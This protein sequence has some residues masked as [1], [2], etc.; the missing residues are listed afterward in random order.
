MSNS[1]SFYLFVSLRMRGML[2][3]FWIFYVFF[4]KQ[5]RCQNNLNSLLFAIISVVWIPEFFFYRNRRISEGEAAEK[6]SY[7]FLMRCKSIFKF[8]VQIHTGWI[9]DKG[10]Q[11]PNI[12]E[13]TQVHIRLARWIEWKCSLNRKYSIPSSK[14][15]SEWLKQKQRKMNWH[16]LNWKE[17]TLLHARK[18]CLFSNHFFIK[19]FGFS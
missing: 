1:D 18:K 16:R 8:A 15:H 3:V 17:K 2:I 19:N 5:R 13:K 6:Q 14:R 10:G 12:S 4:W 9:D 11:F 7:P